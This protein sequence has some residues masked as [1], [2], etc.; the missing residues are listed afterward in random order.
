MLGKKNNINNLIFSKK[1]L[2]FI[3]LINNEIFFLFFSKN[4]LNI[5]Q[6]IFKKNL[7]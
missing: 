1:T 5:L 7:F 2:C 6:F 4:N 3:I